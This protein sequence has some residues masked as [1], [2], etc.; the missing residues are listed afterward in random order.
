MR[1]IGKYPDDVIRIQKVLLNN[2]YDANLKECESLW[3]SYSDNM[4][5][6]WMHLPDNDTELFEII[7]G[8][9]DIYLED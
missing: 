3:D 8:Y 6:S 7:S 1:R 4:A 2:W 5:A 9:I